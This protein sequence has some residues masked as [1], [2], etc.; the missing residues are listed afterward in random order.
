MQKK[1]YHKMR[2]KV[3]IATHPYM[4]RK[5]PKH[6]Y[7]Y[8]LHFYSYYS[9]GRVTNGFVYDKTYHK[10]YKKIQFHNEIKSIANNFGY[11]T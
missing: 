6:V 9:N 4:P 8:D 5:L 7:L 11:F 2:R 1:T 3:P 10:F